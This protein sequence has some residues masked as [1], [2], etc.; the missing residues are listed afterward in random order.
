MEAIF[1]SSNAVWPMESMEYK[2]DGS[3]LRER[4]LR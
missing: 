2:K 3:D 1:E 4:M